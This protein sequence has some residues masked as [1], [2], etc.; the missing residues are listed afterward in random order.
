MLLTLK[1]NTAALLLTA[2]LFAA[3]TS[4][5]TPKL[6]LDAYPAEIRNDLA[7]PYENVR[8]HPDDPNA[9]GSLARVFQAW[10]QWETAHEMYTRAI[11]LAPTSFDWHY[12]DACVLE[13]LA[14]P[15]DAVAH[16]RDALKIR[17]EYVAARVRLADALLSAGQLGESRTIFAALVREPKAEPLGLFGLGRILAAEGKHEEAVQAIQQALALFPEWGAAHYSLALSLRALGRR[18]EAQQALQRHVQYGTRWPGV[19]DP[20]L[21][22]VSDL[23]N[24][25]A[26]RFRRA[27]SL[28][29]QGDLNGAITEFESVLADD[30]SSALAHSSLVKLYG[31]TGNWAKA[32]E[33]YRAAVALGSGLAE[34]H[35]DYG[36]LL[37]LQQKWDE[38]QDAYRRAIAVNPVYPE[39]HNNLGQILERNR[40]FEAA[41]G[42]YRSAASD[43]PTFR[44]AR[45]NVGRMLI[46]LGRLDEAITE[47]QK[48]T[49]PRDAEAPRYLFALSTA[50]VRAGRKD[51]GI[52]WANDA[53][54]LALHYGDTALAAAIERDLALIR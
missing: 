8:V 39:A 14:R 18:D 45:L 15:H 33:H 31:R 34:L 10:E 46:A 13:R 16:L 37:G 54:Q 1:T 6:S 9:V 48:I 28:A 38:A 50:Y 23:R 49:Q 27:R 2:S 30:K 12:L 11:T 32:D 26:A 43:R 17:P 40:Q 5:Q 25:S 53:R 7:R 21:S 29:D 20:V 3:R 42:E 44:L 52:R 51:E 35:Y 24:D 19:P 47:L 36:V 22:S 4:A 41:L